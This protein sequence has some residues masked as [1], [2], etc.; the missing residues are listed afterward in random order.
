M[1]DMINSCAANWPMYLSSLASGKHKGNPSPS[2]EPLDASVRQTAWEPSIRDLIFAASD[3]LGGRHSQLKVETIR[4]D[5]TNIPSVYSNMKSSSQGQLCLT[6]QCRDGLSRDARRF[7]NPTDHNLPTFRILIFLLE[8]QHN[9]AEYLDAS[10]F[11]GMTCKKRFYKETDMR[12]GNMNWSVTNVAANQSNGDGVAIFDR[13]EQRHLA[14]S[15]AHAMKSIASRLGIAHSHNIAEL[16]QNIGLL[17]ELVGANVPLHPKLKTKGRRSEPE[18]SEQWF[19][20]AIAAF[21]QVGD[22]TSNALDCRIAYLS[23]L[24]QLSDPETQILALAVRSSVFPEWSILWNM[25]ES[26]LDHSWRHEIPARLTGLSMIQM[27]HALAEE[28]KL[29]CG[30]LISAWRG[31]DFRLETWLRRYFRTDASSEQEMRALLLKPDAPTDLTLDDFNAIRPQL[32]QATKILSGAARGEWPCNILLYGPP[33]T[34]KTEVA[35]LL[36]AQAGLPAVFVGLADSEGGEPT[37]D[38][39]TAHLRLLRNM[40]SPSD[41]AA[42]I[43]DEAEDLFRQSITRSR[44]KLWLNRLVEHKTAPHIWIVNNPEELGEVVV[45]RMD[46][47]IR[48]EQPNRAEREHILT[49]LASK[50]TAAHS[51]CG[52][53]IDIETTAKRL[54]VIN[55]S[56]AIFRAALINMMRVGGDDSTAE[57]MTEQLVLATGRNAGSLQRISSDKFDPELCNADSDLISLTQNLGNL[58]RDRT[59]RRLASGEGWNMLLSG[60]PGTGKSAYAAHLAD[61]LGLDLVVLQG[62]DLLSAYIGETEKSIA[63]AFASAREKP[64]LLLIDEVDG[65]LGDRRTMQRSWE[66]TQINALLTAM[67]VEQSRFVATT[68]LDDRLDPASARRFSL[69]VRFGSLARDQADTLFA[70]MF[71]QTAPPS[72]RLIEG[73]TPGDF[74][75]AKQRMRFTPNISGKQITQWLAKAVEERGETSPMGFIPSA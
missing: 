35:K 19:R 63:Q 7:V 8:R 34:G 15:T 14:R 43:I 59:R 58:E 2:I 47:V 68:N 56:P 73:L 21:N 44:S 23:R 40:V 10:I 65:F 75:Q 36:A 66:I 49:R 64:V 33:G 69:H 31:D 74:A 54:S 60:P 17:S 3:E 6:Y 72:L 12:I 41:P 71:G 24:S 25:L 52:N 70:Q 46:F 4:S 29:I 1:T 67:E 48:F 53:T 13:T 45:R 9:Y 5:K 57:W 18:L 26:F 16:L 61:A 55:A 42:L 32:D 39:R 22:D 20:T 27:T 51:T 11:D 37:S 30:N 28:N 38:E 62:A 50:I